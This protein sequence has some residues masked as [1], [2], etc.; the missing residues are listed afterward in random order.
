MLGGVILLTWAV[1][2]QG[3]AMSN[4][5]NYISLCIFAANLMQGNFSL[6]NR[7]IRLIL[8]A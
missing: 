2:S 8:G 3:W 7:L 6:E 4:V 1:K 5:T